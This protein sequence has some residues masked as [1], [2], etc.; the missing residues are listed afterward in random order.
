MNP[1]SNVPAQ[2]QPP[3]GAAVALPKAA[4]T[5]SG[6]AEPSAAEQKAQDV[7]MEASSDAIAA[8]A[9]AKSDVSLES[10]ATASKEVM[11]VVAQQI[12]GY[13]KESGRNLNVRVDESTGRY[14]ARVV[15]PETGEVVRSLPSDETLRIAR[16]IDQMRGMLVNQKV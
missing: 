16:N 8:A 5:S 14:V 3:Q 15:N 4:A 1:I 12:Q 11:Q 9:R 6:K 2:G 7:K 10:Y 13:L